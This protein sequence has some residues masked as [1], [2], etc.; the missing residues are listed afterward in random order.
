MGLFDLW[1]KSRQQQT[2]PPESGVGY[3]GIFGMLP[4]DSGAV[5]NQLTAVGVSAVWCAVQAIS[6]AIVGLPL[7]VID[8][9]ED[10]GKTIPDHPILALL[11]NEGEADG[12]TSAIAFKTAM[13]VSLGLWGNGYALISRDGKTLT[14][15]ALKVLSPTRVKPTPEGY[16]KIEGMGDVGPGDVFHVMGPMTLNG[17]VGMSPVD[18]A[19]QTLGLSISLEKF[20]AKFFGQGGNIG[21]IIE[22]PPMK[23]E[24]R[25][26]FIKSWRET[27]TGPDA[28][29][30]IA[31]LT[32]GMKFHQTTADPKGSQSLESREFQVR[33]VSRIWGVPPHML[34]DLEKSSYASIEAQNIDFYTRTIQPY[35]TRWEA[36]IARKLLPVADRG[37]IRARFNMDARLRGTTNE[38]YDAYTKGRQGGWLSINDIRRKENLPPVPGGDALLQPLNMVPVGEKKPGEVSGGEKVQQ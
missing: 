20:A 2:L 6:D 13:N 12:R 16:Y 24:A 38:R 30:K 14:P 34:G 11:G 3:F 1:S 7:R 22:T 18:Y 26:A 4:N 37:K 31:A 8:G 10:E 23:D 15:T 33:E 35:I 36:E 28:A 27:Y 19:R 17:C 29:F 21:G 9:G 5:V 32:G 25:Q